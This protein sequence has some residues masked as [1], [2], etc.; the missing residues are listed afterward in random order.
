MTSPVAC[1]QA[2]GR[3]PLIGEVRH[4]AQTLTA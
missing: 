1:S 4:I 3:D 2:T